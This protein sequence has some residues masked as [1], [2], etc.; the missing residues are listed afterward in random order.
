MEKRYFNTLFLLFFFITCSFANAAAQ[1]S[2]MVSGEKLIIGI[3]PTAPFVMKEKGNYSGLSI[4]SW[5][6]VNAKLGAE[7]EFREYGSL[8]DF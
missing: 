7:Y 2:S 1:D 8:G 5:K 6:M 4:K 3:T